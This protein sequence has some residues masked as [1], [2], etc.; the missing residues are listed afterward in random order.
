MEDSPN[1]FA[2][3]AQRAQYIRMIADAALTQ[4]T[5]NETLATIRQFDS[6]PDVN[7][8]LETVFDTAVS[9]SATAGLTLKGVAL[10][11]QHGNVT[12]G[13]FTPLDM[14]IIGESELAI[15]AG[16]CF[17]DTGRVFSEDLGGAKLV[18]ALE[19]AHQL[20]GNPR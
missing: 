8:A 1:S 4:T 2:D 18:H 10:F 14:C 20:L 16:L 15:E 3:P 5:Q 11:I 12:F 6:D 19:K 7:G 13:G 9:I 17:V